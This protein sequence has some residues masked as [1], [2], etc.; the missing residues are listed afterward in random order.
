MDTA[1]EL[2]L[3][4]GDDDIYAPPDNPTTLNFATWESQLWPALVAFVLFGTFG[5]AINLISFIYFKK[6]P[7]LGNRFQ[8][9]L[10]A[11]DFVICSY[12]ICV[13][14]IGF[15]SRSDPCVNQLPT[16]SSLDQNESSVS[17]ITKRM[18]ADPT[19]IL[20][21]P[22][23]TNGTGCPAEEQSL[24]VLK[25]FQLPGVLLE[26]IPAALLMLILAVSSLLT[27]R[28]LSKP[29]NHLSNH[30]HAATT[31]LLISTVYVLCIR[32]IVTA[33]AVIRLNLTRPTTPTRKPMRTI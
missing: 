15:V 19:S 4:T 25:K 16:A 29:S 32:S 6:Q 27:L 14:V 21:I 24:S 26:V 5:L 30:S 2:R 33:R 31:A 22:I 20:I 8:M 12:Y 23:V 18:N 7:G 3:E 1:T 9:V 28:A 17:R 13:A 11:V 10:N